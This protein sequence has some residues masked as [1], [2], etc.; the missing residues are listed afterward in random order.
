[1]DILE[2]APMPDFPLE[3][4]YY[5]ENALWTSMYNWMFEDKS[6]RREHVTIHDVTLRDGD[7]TPGVVLLE[8][9]RVRIGDALAEMRVPR[10]EA[11][12]PVVGKRV[13]NA[14]RRMVEKKYPHSK[15]YAF[16]RAL[17]SDI[18]LALD[19]GCDGTIVE[20]T[21]N[22]YII[23]HAYRKTP[24]EVLDMLV[25]AINR[26]KD[27]GMDA[28]FMGWDWFRTPLEYTKWLVDGLTKKT[29]MDG[30]VLVDTYGSA[31]P[32]AVEGMVERFHD[33]FPKLRLEFHGH[34]DIGC[35]NANC[36]AAVRAGA[37]VVHTAVHGLGER[38]GNVSTE[39]MAVILA[40]HKGVDTG[41]DL[42]KLYP[43]GKLV[44]TISKVPIHDNKPV[45][46]KRPYMAES[47]IA[48]DIAYKLSH[49][50]EQ[51][52]TNLNITVE[53]WVIGRNDDVEFVLGKSSGKNSIRLFLD[54][55]GLTA[56]D[57]QVA[58]ILD[59]VQQEALVTKSLV[60][61]ETFLRFAEIVCS[62]Q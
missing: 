2:N 61:E 57:E 35:G 33:W 46:G 60:P 10:I 49:N 58:Q 38:C 45:L 18:D 15:I 47:G 52:I 20:Y 51:Q 44:S 40:L 29:A 37:E 7:Q 13:E 11:G 42:T 1:M 32:E 55:N 9:E 59:M 50:S 12:M 30:L 41:M 24:S 48:M 23:K 16:S 6:K 19:I 3:E 17:V 22:P 14:M 36:L 56:T 5:R 21:V 34:N 4:P 27:G 25:S 31:T 62:G 54:K 43:T 39:E 8:D 28:A 53:P 26:A